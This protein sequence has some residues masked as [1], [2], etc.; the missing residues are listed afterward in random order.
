[1][2]DSRALMIGVSAVGVRT[3]P[4]D[5]PDVETQFRVASETGV[6]DYI[7]ASPPPGQVETY[8][9]MAE[10]YRLPVS[11]GGFFY[12]KGRDEP[13]ID[14]H[15]NVVARLGGH[16][17]NIQLMASDVD[18]IPIS[19]QQVADLYVRL[20]EH[21]DR[22]GVTPCF[23]IHVNMWSENFARVE[24]VAALVARQGVK[25]NITLDHSHVIF[26]IDN[27]VE[28]KVQGLD[29]EIEKGAVVLDPFAP[30]SVCSRW[31]SQNL[32]AHAHARGSIP[33]NPLNIKATHPDGSPGRGIQ[34]PF[35]EPAPG[36]WHAEW[37]AERLEPWKEVIRRLLF[38]H[39]SNP[40]S[41]LGQISAEYIGFVDYGSG[42]SYSIIEQ[43]IACARWIRESWAETLEKCRPS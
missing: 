9:R 34:Y 42:G 14:W 8:A 13:L 2:M 3:L 36:T 7:E 27:P 30:D 19:D 28:Q 37:H 38:H 12:T 15:M 41:C 17:L 24:R 21:G 1:M 6:F 4:D 33:A 32:V 43:N 11:V 20:A 31:I 40:D 18:G 35:V 29:A 10:R 26:K 39:A 25:F 23:E 16:A 5:A 22:L